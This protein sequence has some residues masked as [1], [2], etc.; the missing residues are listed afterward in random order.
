MNEQKD[1]RELLE[2]M[3]Q[4][5]REQAKFA[6]LQCLFS[7]IAAVCC[8]AILVAVLTI[9]PQVKDMVGQVDVVLTNVEEVSRQLA[10]ADVAAVMDNLEA[11]TKE[12]AD[13]D[14]GGMVES[15]D[16]LVST[17]QAGVEKALDKLNNIDFETL[18]QAIADLAAVVEPLANFFGRFG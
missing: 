3:D 12:L 5:N 6:K 9:L 14:L 18:N 8:I 17:S 13:A 10:D 1:L 4:S 7:V 16:Q 11:V 15:V 2:R